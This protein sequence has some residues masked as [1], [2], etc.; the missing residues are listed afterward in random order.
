MNHIAAPADS[1]RHR[2]R[3]KAPYTPFDVHLSEYDLEGGSPR[4]KDL[5]D[6]DKKKG[7]HSPKHVIPGFLWPG[8][9]SHGK[10]NPAPEERGPAWGI[11][12][13]A[14]V[15]ADESKGRG[16]PSF[17]NPTRSTDNLLKVFCGVAI[18]LIM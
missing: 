16:T 11:S 4:C 12:R 7:H 1:P 14:A 9:L 3:R 5:I 8:S 17:R 10:V 2:K 13:M 15:G 18:L 6:D